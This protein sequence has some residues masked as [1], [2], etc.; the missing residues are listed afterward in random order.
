MSMAALGCKVYGVPSLAT[1]GAPSAFVFGF[2]IFKG[3]EE[4]G[5]VFFSG[6]RRVVLVNWHDGQGRGPGSLGQSVIDLLG[7]DGHVEGVV[8]GFG[9]LAHYF[10]PNVGPEAGDEEVEGDVVQA[11][12][13]T[14]VHEVEEDFGVNGD[15]ESHEFE[16]GGGLLP[17]VGRKSLLI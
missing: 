11:V 9:S 15:G 1:M 12:L 17:G 8:E 4:I 6:R 13:D 10:L 7:L 3:G 14:K 5:F 2:D 16:D